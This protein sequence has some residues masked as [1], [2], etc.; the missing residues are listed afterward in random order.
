M[1][2]TLLHANVILEDHIQSDAYV[3]FDD[4]TSLITRIGSMN[5][6]LM[7]LPNA[8]DCTGFYVSPG[9]IDTHTH[10]GGGCDFM[11]G[12]V[13]SILTA[14]HLHLHHGTTTIFPTTLTSSNED[15]FLCILV[16]L[17]NRKCLLLR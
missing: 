16:F 10:G 15:L 1:K 9:F 7:H 12:N 3:E 11:D 14:A 17:F 4:E 8:I 2:Q 5:E 6:S 13:E